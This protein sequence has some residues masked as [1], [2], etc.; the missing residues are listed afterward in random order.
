MWYCLHTYAF[1][2]YFKLTFSYPYSFGSAL[3]G[4]ENENASV[5][6]LEELANF[7]QYCGMRKGKDGT[8][9]CIMCG[10]SR[11]YF[12]TRKEGRETGKPFSVKASKGVC[13]SC[14]ALVWKT[15]GIQ[16][17]FCNQCRN[18]CLLDDFVERRANKTNAFVG[19][20]A[21]CRDRIAVLQKVK[22]EN[23]P[24]RMT[25]REKAARISKGKRVTNP[26]DSISSMKAAVTDQSQQ[27]EDSNV[28]REAKGTSSDAYQRMNKPAGDPKEASRRVTMFPLEFVGI[29]CSECKDSEGMMDMDESD[30]SLSSGGAQ[31][32]LAAG[33]RTVA[34]SQ[35]ESA[36][37]AATR[38]LVVEPEKEGS[39]IVTKR[40]VPT[41]T[42]Q[43]TPST[44]KKQ[45]CL[46]EHLSNECKE[47]TSPG[48][49]SSSQDGMTLAEMKSLV[50][51]LDY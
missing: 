26:G 24:R 1:L 19:S 13:T 43:S 30:S 27:E 6:S 15:N 14:E 31:G 20:C 17:R 37:F 33:T 42:I 25:K 18:F 44:S 36:A 11:P 32:R 39:T 8:K 49:T 23:G 21:P 2:E 46:E 12:E 35:D 45:K 51:R 3:W 41:E 47:A 10:I 4:A 34:T 38:K 5:P 28:V 40:P 16:V 50:N 22:R 9:F 48:S 29:K 7:P